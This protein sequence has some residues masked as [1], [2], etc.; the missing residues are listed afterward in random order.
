MGELAIEIKT[1]LQEI[2]EKT[3]MALVPSKLMTAQ[4]VMALLEVKDDATFTKIRLSSGFPAP[5]PLTDNMRRWKKSDI[6]AWIDN[7]GYQ[8]KPKTGRKRNAT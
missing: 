5:I 1:A 2:V 7:G 3:E 8:Q 6:D 4:Q